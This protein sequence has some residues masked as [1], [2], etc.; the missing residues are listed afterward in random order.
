MQTA[1]HM[2]VHVNAKRMQ[3]LHSCWME[4]QWAKL[5]AD[6]KSKSASV[7]FAPRHDKQKSFL[8]KGQTMLNSLDALKL[9]CF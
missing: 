9:I 2:Y 8:K 4:R 1:A 5:D 6:L 3:R 7:D